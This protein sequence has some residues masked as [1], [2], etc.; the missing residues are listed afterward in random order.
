MRI[1]LVEDEQRLADSLKHGLEQSGYVVDH[2]AE[3]LPAVDRLSLYRNEENPT[4]FFLEI[5]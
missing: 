4:L 2:F 3:G 5:D 1:L